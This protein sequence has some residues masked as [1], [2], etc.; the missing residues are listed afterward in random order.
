[1]TPLLGPMSAG[2]GD[3]VDYSAPY[4]VV[5]NGELVTKYPPRQ[6]DAAPG[7]AAEPSSPAPAARKNRSWL[8]ALMIAALVAVAALAIRRWR[9]GTAGVLSRK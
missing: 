4:L 2:A 5:E 6:H 9:R 1:M 7:A 8:P 3:E